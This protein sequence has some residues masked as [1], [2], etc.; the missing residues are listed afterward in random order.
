[1]LLGKRKLSVTDTHKKDSE[2]TYFDNQVRERRARQDNQDASH[3]FEPLTSLTGV[4]VG[5][6]FNILSITVEEPFTKRLVQAVDL[7]FIGA[8]GNNFRAT[9]ISKP[10]FYLQ[11]KEGSEIEVEATLKKYFGSKISSIRLVEINDLSTPNHVATMKKSPFLLVESFTVAELNEISKA[12]LKT[13]KDSKINSRL[14]LEE[15]KENDRFQ[16]RQQD[17]FQSILQIREYDVPIISRAMISNH[18]HVGLWYRVRI[19]S[20]SSAVLELLPELVERPQPV[21]FA[22]DIETTKAPLKF[23]DAKLGDKIMMISWMVDGKGYLGVNRE[24]VSEDIEDFTYSPSPQFPGDFTVFNE[25]DEKALLRRFLS[26]IQM[27]C[28]QIFVTYNGDMFDWPF[29]FERARSHDIQIEKEIGMT[30]NSGETRGRAAIHL[31]CLHWVNRD[32]YLPQGS[33]GLKAVTRSLL[34]YDPLELDPEEMLQAAEQTPQVLASYSVSDAVCTY[35]LYMR[36]VH[37]F[38]FSLCNIVPLP[39]EDVLRKGSGT[40]CEN[41]LMKESHKQEILCPNKHGTSFQNKFQGHLLENETYVGGHVEALQAG[42]F[43]SDL[44]VRFSLSKEV[45]EQLK[46]SLREILYHAL[47]RLKI[48]S[49][50]VTNFEQLYQS[51]YQSL[52]SLKDNFETEDFSVIYHLDVGAMYPNIILTNRLQPHAIVSKQQCASCAFNE[53]ENANCK[54]N[55]KWTW[56]GEYY[57]AT[58]GEVEQ[59]K[60][61]ILLNQNRL[62]VES[63][64]DSNDFR[65]RLKQ[66]CQKIYKKTL[67]TCVEERDATVCQREHP[68]YVNAVR[69]FRDRRYEYKML[70]KQWR[71]RLQEAENS[72][73]ALSVEEAHRM[74]ILYESLQL[75]H[76]CILNSFY[77]YVMRKAARWYSMEMA[78]VVTQIGANIIRYARRIVDGIGI[79]LELDTDGIWCALPKSFPEKVNF[80]TVNKKEYETSFICEILNYGVN[81]QFSNPQYQTLVDKEAKIFEQQTFCSIEFEFDGPYYAMILPASKEEGKSIKKRYAVFNFDGTMAEIKGF[82][83][84]RRGELKLIKIFQ[85]DLFQKFLFGKT[86]QECYHK[87]GETA[88]QWMAVLETK[89]ASCTEEEIIELLAE[90]NT[91]SKSLGEYLKLKQ[92]SLAI[93]TAKRIAEFLGPQMVRDKG[94]TCK[95]LIAKKPENAQ[96]TER[97]IPVQ[98]FATERSVRRSFLKKWLRETD[99]E[100]IQL[101]EFLDWDYYRERLASVIQKIITIPAAFQSIDNPVPRVGHPEWLLRRLKEKLGNEKQSRVGDFFDVTNQMVHK[102]VQDIESIVEHLPEKAAESSP[103]EEH[104][105]KDDFCGNSSAAEKPDIR[106]NFEQWL[107]YM[108]KSWKAMRQEKR[109]KQIRREAQEPLQYCNDPESRLPVSRRRIRK[110]IR[111]FAIPDPALASENLHTQTR[112]HVLSIQPTENPQEFQVW[113]IPSFAAWHERYKQLEK[114]FSFFLHSK[115]TLYIH[116]RQTESSHIGKL[117]TSAHLPRSKKVHNLYETEVEEQLF[118]QRRHELKQFLSFSQV[119]GIYGTQAPLLVDVILRLGNIFTAKDSNTFRDCFHGS[120]VDIKQLIPESS[121]SQY[122]G[123]QFGLSLNK[124][125]LHV[126]L[127]PTREKGLVSFALPKIQKLFLF[128][129]SCGRHQHYPGMDMNHLLKESFKG[130]PDECSFLYSCEIVRLLF[131]SY[132]DALKSLSQHLVELLKPSSTNL[133]ILFIQSSLPLSV[134]KERC[135]VTNLLPINVVD[136]AINDYD[137][138]ALGWEVSSPFSSTFVVMTSLQLFLVKR[139]VQRTLHLFTKSKDFYTAAEKTGIPL[140]NLSVSDLY[141]QCFDIVWA[142]DLKRNNFV[143][144]MSCNNFPDVGGQETESAIYDLLELQAADV[145]EKEYLSPGM[146]SQTCVEFEL[147][148][149]CLCT[150]LSQNIISELEGADV[151]LDSV[152]T[153]HSPHDVALQVDTYGFERILPIF[154]VLR[155]SLSILLLNDSDENGFIQSLK[156]HLYRWLRKETSL[157]HEPLLFRFIHCQMQKVLNFLINSLIHLGAIVPLATFHKMIIA[158]SRSKAFD[159]MRYCGFLANTIRENPLFQYLHFSPVLSVHSCLLFVDQLNYGSIATVNEEDILNGKLVSQVT[160]KVVLETLPCRMVWDLTKHFTHDM[161]V[162]WNETVEQYLR[163]VLSRSGCS[164]SEDNKLMNTADEESFVTN[165]RSKLYD[166]V[167]HWTE[168][169]SLQMHSI[170]PHP[171]RLGPVHRPVVLFVNSLTHILSLYPLFADLSQSFKRDLLLV[172]G[173]GEFSDEA[174]VWNGSHSLVVPALCCSTCGCAMYIDMTRSPE[175]VYASDVNDIRCIR[176]KCVINLFDIENRLKQRVQNWLVLYQVQD[177]KVAGTNYVKRGRLQSIRDVASVYEPTI[178]KDPIV[179]EI[180]LVH[181]VAPDWKNKDNYLELLAANLGSASIPDSISASET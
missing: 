38:I 15:S 161:T 9:I 155:Q 164:N 6:L 66:Y 96:V 71:K 72:S 95:Y 29:I 22:F 36:Y 94:L 52:E 132:E 174:V 3:S 67:E 143:L 133:H 59:M 34:G 69:A 118:L 57:P 147:Q 100:A 101:R 68:F 162:T 92:K 50:K 141:S 173:V 2:N 152:S 140:G 46:G 148:N 102:Q 105:P 23:P 12:I 53:V 54:R 17:G 70:L 137:I 4:R 126:S 150:I 157:L 21:V 176:C 110:D 41:L 178:L 166:L 93:T 44:P 58:H 49:S 42:V 127:S 32:S 30:C 175:F 87:V 74:C 120:H 86:L 62:S 65:Q 134:L 7:F 73:D 165:L 88:N 103:Q 113:V 149:L 151:P 167:A 115:R 108:K 31:D 98:I 168:N 90:Q 124:A 135:F 60:R 117:L 106:K 89:G 14:L 138:P 51:L 159:A 179:K 78:G 142:R 48:D 43:R 1:M 170:P 77:G 128:F 111:L 83:M 37:P 18:I 121:D 177:L 39:P 169:E 24:I 75:A 40:L 16:R 163:F 160:E 107:V 129:V 139:F 55:L 181:Q 56:K 144:W 10:Y 112:F 45:L 91:M 136:C 97:A 27:H 145:K 5:W 20:N 82:E 61:D 99:D 80:Q 63:S 8:D 119:E 25:K 26:E 158:T 13:V 130:C 114:A 76:K 85:S 109:T 180:T 28:P 123:N 81:Q 122:L 154:N 35:Y 125:F 171:G 146:H 47:G 19:G 79:A 104:V 84:K 172:V 64:E 11:V 156:H 116:C 131:K 153:M 33:R